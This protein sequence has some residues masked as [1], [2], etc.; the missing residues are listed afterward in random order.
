M[1]YITQGGF[2][3]YLLVLI[4][5]IAIALII[6]RLRFYHRIKINSEA[7]LQKI[8]EYLKAGSPESA[9]TLCEEH[10][11]PFTS[12]LKKG[13]LHYKE[14]PSA[15]EE[16]FQSQELR[17]IPNL[18]KH[19]SILSTIAS[20]STL[21]GFTGTVTGMIKA[22]HN[23]AQEGASSPSIV[24]SGISQA[25]LTT[26]AGLLIAIPTVIFVRYFEAIVDK[27]INEIDI[28]THE[29]IRITKGEEK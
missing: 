25:L 1:N 19:L 9:I 24:A 23:I 8:I 3:M 17:E 14:G 5:I 11:T 2:I 22:F 4:S 6:N 7:L 12:V 21:L 18:E 26:A 28:A 15:I 10:D 16:A 29:I 13:L 27:F 20:V